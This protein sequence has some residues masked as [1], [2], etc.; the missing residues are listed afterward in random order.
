VYDW[1][2]LTTVADL[3]GGNGAFLA[4]LLARHRHLRGILL[5]LPH[6]VTHA[7]AVLAAAG[8]ADRCDIIGA[9]FFTTPP[10]T[11]DAYLLKAVIS[12]WD[13]HRATTLLRSIRTAMTPDSR[14]L[15]LD[16]V[17]GANRA[18]DLAETF[19]LH[20]LVLGG[21]PERSLEDFQRLFATVRLG[22]YSVTEQMTLP[23]LDVRPKP[24]P[25]V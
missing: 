24:G 11:A 21:G 16:S 17:V 9:D 13:D 18:G 10:P 6:V 20:P 5:D 19:R 25:S 4:G 23:I 8:V 1:S 22:V 7:P 15:V 14:L 2:S 12:G 3:G